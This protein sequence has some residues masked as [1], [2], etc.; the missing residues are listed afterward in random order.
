MELILVRHPETVVPRGTCYGASD[1]AADEAH[2]AEAVTRLAPQLP[3]GARFVSSPQQRARVL[4]EA[5]A[6]GAVET[7]AR[8]KE[9]DFGDW[10]MRVWDDLPRAEIDAWSADFYGYVPPNGESMGAMGARTLDW[11]ASVEG[12]DGTLVAVAH[13]G[14]WR[15]LAAHLTGAGLENALRFELAWGRMARFER[16][17][18]GVRMT[19]WGV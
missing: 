3:K 14:P 15:A 2:L 8:L 10:E 1:V 12:H 13:G 7:D 4:A 19:A 9:V 17:R 11:W 18:H 6:G 5:L 16:R